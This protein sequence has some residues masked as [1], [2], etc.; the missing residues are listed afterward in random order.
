[1]TPDGISMAPQKNRKRRAKNRR[2]KQTR[3][4]K[5]PTKKP[6][7]TK[8]SAGRLV[9]AG[10]VVVVAGLVACAVWWTIRPPRPEV[11]VTARGDGNP[12]D[13][14]VEKSNQAATPQVSGDSFLDAFGSQIG[15]TPRSGETL[16]DNDALERSFQTILIAREQ[17]EQLK[18]KLGAALASDDPLVLS[19]LRENA[20]ALSKRIN[21]Q[22][23]EFEAELKSARQTRPDDPLVQ[24][25][26][27]ELLMYVGGEPAEMRPYFE[28]AVKGGLERPRLW[29]SLARVEFE[30]NHFTE[31]YALAAKALDAQP[32]NH[33]CW[34][35]YNRIAIGN[36]RFDELIKRLEQDFPDAN[37]RPSWAASM[38]D[39]ARNLRELWRA[40]LKQRAADARRDDLPHAKLVVEHRRF[41]RDEAGNVTSKVEVT[42]EGEMELELFEDQAPE[43]VANF[44]SLVDAGFYD[45]TL[46]MVAE[47]AGYVQGGDPNTKNDDVND[48]GIGGPGYIIHDEFKLPG[49][50]SHFRGSISMVNTGPQSAGS[51]FFICLAPNE[52]FNG[53]FTVFGRIVRGQEVADAITLGRTTA[54]VGHYGKIIPG[55]RLVHAE[56]TRRRDHAYKPTKLSAEPMP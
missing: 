42:G 3:P 15:D 33:Y 49:A 7:S 25:L 4:K 30:S 41:A 45:G 36:E 14:R 47:S 11:D 56:V 5:L 8:S 52:H 9:R 39:R 16:K 1:M 46:F 17:R 55:D 27:G 21:K 53:H 35:S 18:A 54:N 34:E 37:Q 28:R 31:G 43:T 23:S 10:A 19:R 38:L 24:W 13:T 44:I 48:D 51:Q 29:S 26:T 6:R 22:L 2:R 32:Q 20:N 50:R 40:E 12:G